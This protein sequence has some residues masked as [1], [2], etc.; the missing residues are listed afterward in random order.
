MPTSI[1]VLEE[2]F[3]RRFGG[4]LSK[5]AIDETMQIAG[6]GTR[7]IVFA[8][9]AGM[10]AHAFNAV[11]QGGTIRY[12]DGQTGQVASFAGYRNFRLLRTN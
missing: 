12:L 5:E 1:L 10:I 6:P 3:G 4:V 2:Q 8:E 11:N 9:R 7:A